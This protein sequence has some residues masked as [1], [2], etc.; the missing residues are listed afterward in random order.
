MSDCRLGT[1]GASEFLSEESD[2][3]Q[4]TGGY[5]CESPWGGLQYHVSIQA[6][7]KKKKC[8]ICFYLCLIVGTFGASELLSE[9]SDCTQC[10]G[11]FYCESPGEDPQNH[12]IHHS[13]E[14]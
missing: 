4:F 12:D 5:Y 1:F 6:K 11:G 13:K 14:M 8:D 9:E 10:T 3:T 7:K 2:C